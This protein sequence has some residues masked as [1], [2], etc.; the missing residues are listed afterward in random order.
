MVALF[1][2]FILLTRSGGGSCDSG[3]G[4]GCCRCVWLSI[5]VI[6]FLVGAILLTLIPFT[7]IRR[8]VSTCPIDKIEYLFNGGVT[9]QG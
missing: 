4:G 8:F 7:I 9:R 2:F 6:S 1:E 5:L 3:S